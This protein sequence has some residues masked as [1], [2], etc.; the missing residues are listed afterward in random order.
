[1]PPRSIRLVYPGVA[2]F[3]N[4]A[5]WCGHVL[6]ISICFVRTILAEPVKGLGSRHRVRPNPPILTVRTVRQVE[7]SCIARRDKLDRSRLVG[8][9]M[10]L[11]VTSDLS[12]DEVG[13]DSCRTIP[14][15]RLSKPLEEGVA[16]M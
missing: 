15:F 6:P 14:S 3:C 7:K 5:A 16:K 9:L 13:F 8:S 2:L 12:L 11:V 1:M 4:I 10:I